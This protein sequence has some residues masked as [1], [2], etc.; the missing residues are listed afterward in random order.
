MEEQLKANAT[1][2]KFKGTLD[3]QRARAQWVRAA[4]TA[5]KDERF[6]LDIRRR[7]RVSLRFWIVFH[8][9]LWVF[10]LFFIDFH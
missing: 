1:L 10:N 2:Q 6:E 4:F 5:G 7:D 3:R 8:G 9:F